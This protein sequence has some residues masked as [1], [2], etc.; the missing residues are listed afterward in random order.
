MTLKVE[1]QCDAPL[2]PDVGSDSN[3]SVVIYVCFTRS[4][5]ILRPITGTVILD[6]AVGKLIDVTKRGFLIF[7][8]KCLQYSEIEYYVGNIIPF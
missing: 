8:K 1:V 4:G 6:G 3:E 2:T 7:N 5:I